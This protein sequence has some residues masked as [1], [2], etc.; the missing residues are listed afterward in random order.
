MNTISQPLINL[1]DFAPSI[2]EYVLSINP[3]SDRNIGDQK[4]YQKKIY[5]SQLAYYLNFKL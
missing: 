5:L 1:K 3:I 2:T 4:G